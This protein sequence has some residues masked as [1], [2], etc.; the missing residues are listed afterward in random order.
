MCRAHSRGPMLASCSSNIGDHP[1]PSYPDGDWDGGRLYL[2]IFMLHTTSYIHVVCI[3]IYICI[4]VLPYVN[5]QINPCKFKILEIIRI[6]QN[7]Y[8]I[9]NKT[10][11]LG[12]QEWIQTIKNIRGRQQDT[13]RCGRL[14]PPRTPVKTVFSLRVCKCLGDCRALALVPVLSKVLLF[15][16]FKSILQ[17]SPFLSLTSSQTLSDRDSC[18]PLLPL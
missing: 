11:V 2:C 15:S 16:L 18:S 17:I 3:C 5:N 13:G 14:S 12:I 4:L 10:L 7:S 8:Q 6:F 1:C 9:R